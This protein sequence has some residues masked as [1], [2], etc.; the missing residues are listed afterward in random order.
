MKTDIR[1]KIHILDPAFFDELIVYTVW[2]FPFLPRVGE[3]I[4]PD[5]WINDFDF[6][7]LDEFLSYEGK[8]SLSDY[9]HSP[10]DWLHDVCLECCRVRSITYGIDD[11][12]N[13]IIIISLYND[14]A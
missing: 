11:K 4:Y 14:E 1:L 10:E 2:K 7:G 8:S 9:G 12:N 6:S 13:P 3:Y 5:V